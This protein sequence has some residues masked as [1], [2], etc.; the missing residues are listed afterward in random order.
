[1]RWWMWLWLS[2]LLGTSGKEPKVV[3]MVIWNPG[4]PGNY[5]EAKEVMKDFSKVLSRLSGLSVQ[6]VYFSDYERGKQWIEKEKPLLLLLPAFYFWQFQKSWNLTPSL[7]VAKEGKKTLQYVVVTSEGKKYKSLRELRGKTLWLHHGIPPSWLKRMFPHLGTLQLVF[8]KRYLRALKRMVEGKKLKNK[9]V[10][11]LL[12]DSFELK[13][14]RENSYWRKKYGEHL[15]VLAKSPPLPIMVLC[16]TG[17]VPSSLW[18]ALENMEKDEKGKKI[19][20]LFGMDKFQRKPLS[21]FDKWK[22]LSI[23]ENKS[24]AKQ[25]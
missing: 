3:Q 16:H 14:L 4:G 7:C 12:L 15:R 5:E 21:W 24:Q 25:G 9:S 23:M 19:L 8:Y 2:L 1:M 20:A 10:D 18:K 17:K 22:S 6:V 13:K 11:A